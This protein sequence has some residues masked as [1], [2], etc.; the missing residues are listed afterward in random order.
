VTIRFDFRFEDLGLYILD[1]SRTLP[2]RFVTRGLPFTV[3][4]QDHLF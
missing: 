4:F 3:I 1:S 2:V